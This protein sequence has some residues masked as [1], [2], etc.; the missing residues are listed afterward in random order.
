MNMTPEYRFKKADG[1]NF[2]EWKRRKIGDIYTE[3]NERGNDALPIL[4]VS[5]HSGVSG[6]EMDE[7][8]LGKRVNRSEDK[9]LY[10]RVSPGDLVFNMMRAWQGAIGTVKTE[11]MV[12]PAYITAKPSDEVYPPFMDFFMRTDE[13]IHIINRQSYGVTDFRKRLYWDSFANIECFIPSIEEQKK[14]ADFLYT[15]EVLT[16]EKEKEIEDTIQYKVGIMRAIF[17][18]ERRFKKDDGSD[19]PEWK[20]C[21]LGDVLTEYNEKASKG[22]NYEHVSLTK[23]G[24]VPKTERYDRDFLVTQDDKKYRVTHYDDICYNPA[25]LKFGVICRNKYGDAIF[26][27]IYVTFK[28]NEGFLPAYVEA[29]LVRWDFIVTTLKYQQGTVYERMAV[30]S[31]DL[32]SMNIAVPCMDEQKKIADFLTLLDEKI[33]NQQSIFKALVKMKKGYEQKLLLSK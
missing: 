22:E 16:E 32:L 15:L 2:P 3:R 26:S 7:E 28:V 11:G 25:N 6:D 18:Q 31:K 14:I 10:K 30:S 5:I 23:E 29:F 9:S 12:S 24:V 33:E 8:E 27:P 13:M 17:Q 1:S 21:K 20:Y 4:S 19:F